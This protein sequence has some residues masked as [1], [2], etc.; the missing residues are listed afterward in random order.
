MVLFR[1]ESSQPWINRSIGIARATAKNIVKLVA[2]LL[3]SHRD[4][5]CLQFL[6]LASN[7]MPRAKS[8]ETLYTLPKEVLDA[9]TGAVLL[10]VGTKL[11]HKLVYAVLDVIGKLPQL[12][13]PG[14]HLD[15]RVLE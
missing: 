12:G 2:V 5:S 10:T 7:I 4:N 15:V 14:L 9:I 6:N 3:I 1:E 11:V 13:D 8:F